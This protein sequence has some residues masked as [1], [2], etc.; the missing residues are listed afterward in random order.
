MAVRTRLI[1]VGA[2]VMAIGSTAGATAF[3]ADGGTGSS[4]AGTAKAS[5]SAQCDGKIPGGVQQKADKAGGAKDS[6]T[7]AKSLGVTVDQLDS[8]LR[9]T[10]VWI[11]TSGATLTPDTFDQHVASLLGLPVDKVAKALGDGG[12]IIKSQS[13][14]PAAAKI[15]GPASVKAGDASGKPSTAVTCGPLTAADKAK[16]VAEAKS[17]SVDTSVLAKDLGVTVAQLDQA[18][19]ATKQWVADDTAKPTPDAFAQHVASLLKLPADQVLSV[20]TRDGVIVKPGD[21][22]AQK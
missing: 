10:K 21:A 7:I 19:T 9:D 17:R 22:G 18:F 1:A 2:I 12:V 8:A 15:G 16:A 6:S 4:S 14:D 3:A 20:L 5:A 11:G 13:G